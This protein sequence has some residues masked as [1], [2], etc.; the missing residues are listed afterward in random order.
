MFCKKCGKYVQPTDEFCPYCGERVV[1]ENTDIKNDSLGDTKIIGNLNQEDDLVEI[2]DE[3]EYVEDEKFD[4][5]EDMDVPNFEFDDED[6]NEDEEDFYDNDDVE[7][8]QVNKAAITNEN[9]KM[10]IIA[11]AVST[12]GR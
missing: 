8:P 3:V 11:I 7:E 5:P 4:F 10:N 12:F 2:P 1:K 9:K 6:D